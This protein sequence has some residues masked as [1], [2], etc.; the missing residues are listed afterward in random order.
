[1]KHAAPRSP[2]SAAKLGLTLLVV[3]LLGVVAAIGT[4]SAFS[5]TTENPGNTFAAGTVSLC[6]DDA[7]VPPGPP[8]CLGGTP[9]FSLSN[10]VPGVTP[11]TKCIK[12]D[13]SGSLTSSVRLYGTTGGSGL[14]S[15]LTVVVTR[16]TGGAGFP[17]CTG[18]S[19]DPGD[20]GFGPGGVIYS[21]TLQDYPDDY[22]AGRID[23]VSGS[24]EAWNNPESHTYRFV[25]ELPSGTPNAAQG[26]TATQVFTWEARNV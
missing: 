19:P 17:S 24:P 21:G 2:R 13:Y 10:M 23:P 12:V 22:L 1:M 5:S 26:L 3:A 18:F 14:A 11:T 20:Y 8:T 16:G 7:P 25:I 15:H 4:W 9:M 6:D